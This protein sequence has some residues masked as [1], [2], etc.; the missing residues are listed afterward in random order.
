ATTAATGVA[1][2]SRTSLGPR[3][4]ST[5]S[6]SAP[7]PRAP[8][9]AAGPGGSRGLTTA[10]AAVTDAPRRSPSL[11]PTFSS[12]AAPAP[13]PAVTEVWLGGGLCVS[14][15]SP[16]ARDD[17]HGQHHVAYHSVQRS[18]HFSRRLAW[19]RTAGLC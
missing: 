14:V 4:S 8:L 10:T 12:K 2:P 1:P 18:S 13:A 6:C 9:A 15:C 17:I 5:T 11:R 3:S 16:V 19:G 7:L